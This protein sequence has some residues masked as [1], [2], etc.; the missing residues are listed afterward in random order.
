LFQRRQYQRSWNPPKYSYSHFVASITILS[1]QFGVNDLQ[2]DAVQYKLL[3]AQEKKRHFDGGLCLYCGESG[4]KVDKCLKKQ[5]SH[6]FKMKSAT[7]SSNSR[8]ENG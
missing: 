7:I 3:I 5:Y 8:P 6:T 2:I 4:H 1:S